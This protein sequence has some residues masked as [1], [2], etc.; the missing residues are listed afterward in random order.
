MTPPDGSAPEQER[1]DLLRRALLEVKAARAKADALQRARTEPIAGVG[2]GCR[3]P[4]GADGPEAFWDL[5]VSGRNAVTEIPAGRWDAG[6]FYDPDPA[7]P[8]RT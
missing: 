4:G 6:A 7:A 2:I 8:G 3:F 5:L 1:K